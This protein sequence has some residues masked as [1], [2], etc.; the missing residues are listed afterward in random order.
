MMLQVAGLMRPVVCRAQESAPPAKSYRPG[1]A[2][3]DQVAVH[4]YDFPDLGLGGIV[5]VHVGSN[6]TVHLPYAGTIQAT[7]MSPDEFQAAISEAL[8]SRGIVKDP[9][10]TVD[11]ASA[12]NMTVDVIGQVMTPKSV[13]LYAP[14]PVSFVLSQVGGVNG[15]AAHHLVIIHAGE[16]PPTSLDFDPDAPTSAVLHT[17]V[18]PG[19]IVQ[20]SSMGVYFVAGEVNRPGIYPIG[21]GFNLGQASAGSGMGVVKN[22]TLLE[23]LAQTGGITPVAARSKMRI[24]RTIDGKREEIIVDQVKLY[25]GEIADPIIH[26]D[27]IIYVPTSYIRQQTNNLFST[28]LSSLYAATQIKTIGQ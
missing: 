27:D 16:E 1:L 25:K 13:P 8:R 11:V 14:A 4:M 17:M 24:L 7:G 10:V 28:A 9:N 26:P 19:D 15:L 21:G 6:G 20:V 18:Q 12:V 22:L 3:G 2:P 23:A 5:Q